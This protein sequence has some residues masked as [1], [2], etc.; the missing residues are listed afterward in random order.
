LT[1]NLLTVS[2]TPGRNLLSTIALLRSANDIRP[3]IRES[4]LELCDRIT[5][6]KTRLTA[7]GRV[8]YATE[9]GVKRCWVDYRRV[10][11]MPSVRIIDT[12]MAV[13]CLHAAAVDRSRMQLMSRSVEFIIQVDDTVV[14]LTVQL[15]QQSRTLPIY[16]PSTPQTA[17][18]V[19]RQ[20]ACMSVCLGQTAV[21][22]DERPHDHQLPSSSHVWLG[23][24]DRNTAGCRADR[25]SQQL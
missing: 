24:S 5:R 12:R 13:E 21:T 4:H 7:N 10:S 18:A 1:G 11:T 23:A 14:V 16:F 3:W 25:Y 8:L 15:P 6:I 22:H 20:G 19:A 9:F 17:M 2:C